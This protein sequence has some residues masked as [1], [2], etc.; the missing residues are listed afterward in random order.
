M[1]KSGWNELRKRGKLKV[2]NL[3]IGCRESDEM[4]YKRIMI[5]G[6]KRDLIELCEW[7]MRYSRWEGSYE[8]LKWLMEDVS[9]K[10]RELWS[11]RK[12]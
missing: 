7:N 10:L 2:N 9:W 12:R 8:K 5:E 3:R 6:L 1:E 4:R 11:L